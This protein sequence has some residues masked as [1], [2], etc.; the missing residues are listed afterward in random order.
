MRPFH[1]QWK[2]ILRSVIPN[3]CNPF[4]HQAAI[5][6]LKHIPVVWFGVELLWNQQDLKRMLSKLVFCTKMSTNNRRWWLIRMSTGF[7]PS[8]NQESTKVHTALHNGSYIWGQESIDDCQWFCS[9]ERQWTSHR[10]YS[11]FQNGK[12]TMNSKITN[13]SSS[14][15]VMN[16]LCEVSLKLLWLESCWHGGTIFP[17]T[18][19]LIFVSA[20]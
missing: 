1:I 19:L 18:T 3:L 12:K 10:D 9:S 20:F 6:H 13:Y 2:S 16:S 17:K 4:K 7:P 8:P 15:L 5:H 14:I 11:S